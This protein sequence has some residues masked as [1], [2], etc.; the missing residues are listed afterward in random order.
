[1]V[2]LAEGGRNPQGHPTSK[3]GWQCAGPQSR[4]HSNSGS[5]RQE[6]L[7]GLGLLGFSLMQPTQQALKKML[8]TL[9]GHGHVV[10]VMVVWFIPSLKVP[11]GN[12]CQPIPTC[13]VSVVRPWVRN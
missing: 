6:G 13:R 8:P 3:R 5:L 12:M 1:M 7:E 11:L 4:H 10:K 2:T 9:C